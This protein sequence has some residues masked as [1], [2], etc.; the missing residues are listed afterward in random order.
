MNLCS[1]LTD[2]KEK[3]E[4]ISLFSDPDNTDKFSAGFVLHVTDEHILLAS[5]DRKGRYDGFTAKR[6]E[7]IYEVDN[8]GEYEH[9]MQKLYDIQKQ[10]HPEVNVGEDLFNDLLSFAKSNKLFVTIECYDSGYDDVQG[11]VLSADQSTIEIEKYDEYG[12]RD[13]TAVLDYNSISRICCDSE[14]EQVMRMMAENT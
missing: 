2:V 3:H 8:N 4:I 7:D 5:V 1:I 6:S 14:D 13:G 9:K 11:R 10:S 12:R